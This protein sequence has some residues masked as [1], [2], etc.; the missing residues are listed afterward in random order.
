[1][2]PQTV[3]PLAASSQRTHVSRT[4]GRARTHPVTRRVTTHYLHTQSVTTRR[5]CGRNDKHKAPRELYGGVDVGVGGCYVLL[6]LVWLIALCV[7]SFVLGSPG[8]LG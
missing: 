6:M 5:R 2:I 7:G 3:T 8:S 4:Q 1:M